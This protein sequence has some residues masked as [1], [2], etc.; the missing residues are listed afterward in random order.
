MK[1]ERERKRELECMRVEEDIITFEKSMQFPTV[2]D[3]NV[4]YV[5]NHK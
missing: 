2:L 1:G 5:M 4:L 3:D